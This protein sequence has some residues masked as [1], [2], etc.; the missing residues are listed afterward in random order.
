M[1]PVPDGS[2]RKIYLENFN[3]ELSEQL[4]VIIIDQVDFPDNC[5]DTIDKRA[6]LEQREGFWQTQLRT[7]RRYGGLNVKD[8]RRNCNTRRAGLL[9]KG[10]TVPS[11]PTTSDSTLPPRPVERLMDQS[12]LCEPADPNKTGKSTGKRK[13]T[14]SCDP[15]EDFVPPD[16]H[17]FEVNDIPVRRSSRLKGKKHT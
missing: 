14:P 5:N 16:G 6:F 15:D 13:R 2:S 1:L 17:N 9:T 11:N 10:V 12:S 8:E 4:E 3:V 7:L